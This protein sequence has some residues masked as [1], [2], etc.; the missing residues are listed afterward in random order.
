MVVKNMDSHLQSTQEAPRGADRFVLPVAWTVLATLLWLCSSKGIITALLGLAALY[1]LARIRTTWSYWRNPAGIAFLAFAGL[2]L[3]LVPLSTNPSLSVRDM[4]K[5]LPTWGAAFAIPALFTS[6][7]RMWSA[8]LYSAIGLALVLAA[9]LVRLT[10][11][12]GPDL[13]SEARYTR[14][15][16][17]NHPNVAS[18]MAAAALLVLAFQGWRLLLRNPVRATAFFLGALVC[19]AYLFV[20]RSR[21]PQLAF[22]ITVLLSGLLLLPRWRTRFAWGVLMAVVALIGLANLQNLNPRFLQKDATRFTERDRVWSHTWSLSQQHPLLGHGPGKKVFAETYYA[23]D[24][25]PSRFTFPHAH[26]YWLM[27]LFES[28][29]V[30]ALLLLTAWGLF[31]RQLLQFVHDPSRTPDEYTP[32]AVL[33]LL[34]LLFH[35]YG[36]GDYPDGILRTA[37]VWL[38]PSAWVIMQSGQPATGDA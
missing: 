31:F 14:P 37:M 7:N 22:G 8:I 27:A 9:D 1:G 16:V 2:L 20:L 6:R 18:L 25:P 23:S 38:V 3:I 10:V 5:A 33:L 4:A 24:P 11:I 17:L 12:L 35:T 34:T 15:Y 19:L 30:G 21:G 13:L 26:Q 28:G 36:L 29:W 32:A